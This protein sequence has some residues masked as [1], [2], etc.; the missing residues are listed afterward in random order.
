MPRRWRRGTAPSR[1]MPIQS[2]EN[3]TGLARPANACGPRAANAIATG[4]MP[5]KIMLMA[6]S[7]SAR[8]P[9]VACGNVDTGHPVCAKKTGCG[10]KVRIAPF[11]RQQPFNTG[12][13][14]ESS[15]VNS[16]YGGIR[17]SNGGLFH[18]QTVDCF[19]YQWPHGS[20]HDPTAGRTGYRLICV[21]GPG[22]HREDDATIGPGAGHRALSVFA[23]YAAKKRG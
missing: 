10:R 2:Q 22:R 4:A 7:V 16:A 19:D 21:L 3:S 13:K 14:N 20:H 15:N 23:A 12:G 11:C 1:T 17:R 18:Q 6:A 5:K 8:P 9:E